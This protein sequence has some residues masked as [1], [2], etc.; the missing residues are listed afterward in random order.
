M[1]VLRREALA[2]IPVCNFAPREKERNSRRLCTGYMTEI[3]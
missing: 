1:M 3:D 2:Y